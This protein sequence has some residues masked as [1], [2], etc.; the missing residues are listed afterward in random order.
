MLHLFRRSLVSLAATSLGLVALVAP[1]QAAGPRHDTTPVHDGSYW[2]SSQAPRGVI[3]NDLY[4]FDDFGLSADA[5]L[6]LQAVDARPKTVKKVV[7]K[8]AEN[9]GA[10]LGYGYSDTLYAGSVAKLLTLAELT[11]A[12]VSAFGGTDLVE[13]VE[14]TVSTTAPIAGRIEDQVDA[15]EYPPDYANVI[16]QSFAV[17]GLTLA[18][19]SRAADATAFLVSQQCEAGFFRLNFASDKSAPDQS[20]DGGVAA[21]ESAPDTDATAFAVL[22]LKGATGEIAEQAYR[23]GLA[24]LAEQQ[25]A[26]GSFGGGITTKKSNA[27][28]TGLAGWALGEGGNIAAAEKAA[29]WVRS[30]QVNSDPCA[31]RLND[32]IGAIAYDAVAYQAGLA[33]GIKI[34]TADQWRRASVQAL[35]VLQWAPMAKAPALSLTLVGRAVAGKTFKLRLTGAAP[36]QRV[37]AMSA[38][39]KY[40]VVKPGKTVTVLKIRAAKGRSSQRVSVVV[41]GAGASMLVNFSR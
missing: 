36:G 13:L 41:G 15:M 6:A 39:T 18:A 11:G 23:S 5:A 1:A 24:W 7:A 3:H 30:Y 38:G 35:P 4:V 20:C 2:L 27:N 26:N 14:S 16:G 25:R 8:L 12:D 31:L 10:Y 33:K 37:C 9:L 40:S 17:R 22:A 32:Q 28:S 21:G 29:A 19:S 34:T